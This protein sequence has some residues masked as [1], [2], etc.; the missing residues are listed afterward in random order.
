VAGNATLLSSAAVVPLLLGAGHAAV[1]RYLLP[2][3][4]AASD[5]P[6]TAAA[7]DSWCRILCKLLITEYN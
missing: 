4:T 5:P 7:V 6:D 1:D 2:D 3:G